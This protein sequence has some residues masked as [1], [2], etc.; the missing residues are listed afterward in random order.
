MKSMKLRARGL[1]RT[2]SAMDKNRRVENSES[3]CQVIS[4]VWCFVF[5]SVLHNLKLFKNVKNVMF[6]HDRQRDD[7]QAWRERGSWHSVATWCTKTRAA[8]CL[9]CIIQAREALVRIKDVHTSSIKRLETSCWGTTHANVLS[10][11]LSRCYAACGELPRRRARRPI[12]SGEPNA[13]QC[14][15]PTMLD[16]DS[17]VSVKT[18]NFC[19][20]REWR[21]LHMS[22]PTSQRPED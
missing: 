20:D 1:F 2:N 5:A 14:T 15:H 16:D 21:G 3:S 12:I 6:G 18:R 11:S 7:W 22:P 13:W 8:L 10:I 4:V 9:I 17:H 19:G